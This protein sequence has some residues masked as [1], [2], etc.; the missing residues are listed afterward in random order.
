MYT[1]QLVLGP[2]PLFCKV[3]ENLARAAEHDGLAVASVGHAGVH[4]A[5]GARGARRARRLQVHLE[6][7][8][9][10]EHVAREGPPLERRSHVGLIARELRRA[11]D[12][13][14]LILGAHVVGRGHGYL[15]LLWRGGWGGGVAGGSPSS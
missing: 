2:A 14:V 8:R 10:P 13:A 3:D 5:D 1:A 9:D 12:Q 15:P 7:P 11:Q 4:G 6:T